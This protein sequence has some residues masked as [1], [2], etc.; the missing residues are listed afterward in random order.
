MPGSF[1]GLGDILR[2]TIFLFEFCKKNNYKFIV[3]LQL[4]SLSKYLITQTHEHMEL[5][6]NNKDNIMFVPEDNIENYIKY[7]ESDVVYFFTKAGTCNRN[8][9]EEDTKEFMK[10]LLT[11]ND[12]LEKYMNEKFEKPSQRYN[13]IHFRLGDDELVSNHYLCLDTYV[14][15]YISIL[16]NNLEPNDILISDSKR[17]K[18]IIKKQ[19][20]ISMFENNPKHIGY[21]SELEDTLFEF[22]LLI[23]SD[24]IKTYSVYDWISGFVFWG[25]LIYDIPLVCIK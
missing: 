9:L 10:Q 16:Q 13:I 19:F 17:F 24:K 20:N 3:D 21:H 23:K 18:E 7:F 1:W 2:G 14:D 6:K 25:H 12:F 11:P 22:F 15:T 4:H 5:V 8:F